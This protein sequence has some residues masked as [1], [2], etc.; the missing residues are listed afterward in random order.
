MD[1]GESGKNRILDLWI[2]DL[3]YLD[4]GYLDLVS[5]RDEVIKARALLRLNCKR[6]KNSFNI[7]YKISLVVLQGLGFN[8]QKPFKNKNE[9]FKNSS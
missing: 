7:Q 9:N 2:L 6:E 1:N 5:G 3:G 8:F 4:L